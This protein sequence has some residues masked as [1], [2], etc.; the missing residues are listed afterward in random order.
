M[1]EEDTDLQSQHSTTKMP[2]RSLSTTS[3]VHS[4]ELST[5]TEEY[6]EEE[7]YDPE[8]FTGN[9]YS[10]SKEKYCDSSRESSKV[11]SEDGY[12]NMSANQRSGL[13][14]TS[15]SREVTPTN[16][17]D[18]ATKEAWAKKQD[19]YKKNFQ[20]YHKLL[21]MNGAAGKTR[22]PRAKGNSMF[23]CSFQ[24][25]DRLEFALYDYR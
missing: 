11:R 25:V 15:H 9:E 21:K 24:T 18:H 16:Q 20:Y 2:R 12:T 8:N 23:Q 3:S 5:G 7:S 13:R 4:F 14:S 10:P 19:I 22:K 17:V 1:E 6:A